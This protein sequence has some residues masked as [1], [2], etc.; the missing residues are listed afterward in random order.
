MSESRHGSLRDEVSQV[1]RSDQSVLVAQNIL[2][3]LLKLLLCQAFPG[4]PGT[5][6]MLHLSS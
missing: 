2:K 1:C 5:Q 6:E 3:E 4:A